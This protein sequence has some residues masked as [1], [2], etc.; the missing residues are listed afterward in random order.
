MH[1]FM[2]LARDAVVEMG[3]PLADDVSSGQEGVGFVDQ[4]IVKGARQSAADGYLRPV[5]DSRRNLTVLTNALVN[6]LLI[7]GRSCSCC[8]AS[9]RPGSCVGTGSTLSPTYP[10]RQQPRVLSRERRALHV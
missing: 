4:N 10:A 8:P 2:E 5:M 7:R 9:G 6:R 3:I 1:P